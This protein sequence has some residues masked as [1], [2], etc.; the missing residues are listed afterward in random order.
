M[1]RFLT[2]SEVAEL[3]ELLEEAPVRT[4][5]VDQVLQAADEGRGMTLV[6]RNP[7]EL[8]DSPRTRST[9]G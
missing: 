5:L 3:A 1:K 8:P 4:R 7:Q 6:L 9:G 2:P